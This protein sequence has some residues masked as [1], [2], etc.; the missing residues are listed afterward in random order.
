MGPETHVTLSVATAIGLAVMIWRSSAQLSELKTRMDVV[1][2]YLMRR[3]QAEGIHIGAMTR[4][5]P[6]SLTDDGRGWFTG[7]LG[8]KLVNWYR[9][10][11][12]GL[13]ERDLYLGIEKEFGEVIAREVCVPKGVHAGAC[14]AAAVLF[15]HESE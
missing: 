3:G 5:S 4:N 2:D 8:E 9:V 6:L 11:G 13:S 10:R 15:C 14:L 12:K 1:W 7:E